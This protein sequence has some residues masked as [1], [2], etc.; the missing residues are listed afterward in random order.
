MRIF[1]HKKEPKHIDFVYKTVKDSDMNNL[2]KGDYVEIS[3]YDH[4]AWI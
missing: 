3:G 4:K 2:Q 1:T